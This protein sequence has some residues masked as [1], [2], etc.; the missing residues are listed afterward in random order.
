VGRRN[1]RVVLVHETSVAAGGVSRRQ[2][3][4]RDRDVYH[5][6]PQAPRPRGPPGHGGG[7]ALSGRR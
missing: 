6:E 1:A 4:Q 3:H 2:K 7:G 5:R